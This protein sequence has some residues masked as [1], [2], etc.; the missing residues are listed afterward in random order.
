MILQSDIYIVENQL[1]LD[2]DNYEKLVSH[3]ARKQSCVAVAYKPDI[4][5]GLGKVI[6]RG[7]F[8]GIVQRPSEGQTHILIHHPYID[9]PFFPDH[10]LED[11]DRSWESWRRG[12]MHI[13]NYDYGVIDIAMMKKIT[14]S[15]FFTECCN[16]YHILDTEAMEVL[17][18]ISRKYS[19]DSLSPFSRQANEMSMY[20]TLSKFNSW[21]V[22]RIEET[23]RI[24]ICN[25]MKGE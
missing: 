16:D 25:I 6:E 10:W 15:E 13:R 4:H 17:L 20:T 3:T 9:Y 7:D 1:I 8:M 19:G 22:K 23:I 11:K 2:N 5:P 24:K 12:Y 21:V 18:D 14:P